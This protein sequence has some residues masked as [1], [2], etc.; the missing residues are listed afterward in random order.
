MD[1]STVMTSIVTERLCGSI[2]HHLTNQPI[3]R[4]QK[5]DVEHP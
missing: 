4:N 3:R 1:S 5:P 2:S